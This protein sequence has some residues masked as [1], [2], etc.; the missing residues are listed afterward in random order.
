MPPKW[1]ARHE[2]A[3]GIIRNAPE[4]EWTGAARNRAGDSAMNKRAPQFFEVRRRFAVREMPV[5]FAA[6]PAGSLSAD[7]ISTGW[8][9]R[10]VFFHG[11]ETSLHRQSFSDEI[12]R[13]E[14]AENAAGMRLAFPKL[15]VFFPHVRPG[16]GQSFF[17]RPSARRKMQTI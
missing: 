11:M 8:K 1:A 5:A 10:S 12:I 17:P 16:R 6:G 14:S 7:V 15:T 2:A 3:R 9:T 13:L 4:N